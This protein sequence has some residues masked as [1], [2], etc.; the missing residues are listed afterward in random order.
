MMKKQTK[1]TEKDDKAKRKASTAP[2]LGDFAFKLVKKIN[3]KEYSTDTLD[4]RHVQMHKCEAC[5]SSFNI[6]QV[7]S[8]YRLHCKVAKATVA[9]Q[10]EKMKMKNNDIRN[11]SDALVENRP[12]HVHAKP[13]AL[14]NF[15]D[16]LCGQHKQHC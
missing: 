1:C 16:K 6:S 9:A 13:R 12:K 7:I 15:F 11:L 4:C 10:E 5:K 3:G 8:G 2:N 14:E